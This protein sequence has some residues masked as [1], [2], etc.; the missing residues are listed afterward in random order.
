MFF[1]I[2]KMIDLKD[3]RENIY[4]NYGVK[5]CPHYSED[6]VILKIFEEIGLDKKHKRIVEFGETRVLG[7]TTRSFRIKY[8]PYAVYFTQ[9]IDIMSKILNIF[10]I[11][12]ITIFTKKLKYLSFF[13]N[14][15]FKFFVTSE[16]IIK[17]LK[18]KL[19]K[20][21]EIDILTIDID[22]YDYFVSKLILENDYKPRLLVLEYNPFLPI[23]VPLSCP[24]TRFLNNKPKNKRVYGASYLAMD[25]L[26]TNYGYKLVHVSGF[27]NLFYIRN[28]YAD[29]FTS[30]D[31]NVELTDSD[32]K[33]KEFINLFCQ[34]GFVPSWMEEK[35]LSKSDLAYFERV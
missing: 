29:I 24:N 18:G 13:N 17:I 20:S 35:A 4:Q 15:P 23:D 21:K 8:L 25:N 22:S 19:G 26:A 16:N 34:K 30:P 11:I 6:G 33:V 2:N 7:T 12:K 32:E 9:K 28:E 10:D 31:I 1:W 14:M 27:C 5:E 3:F